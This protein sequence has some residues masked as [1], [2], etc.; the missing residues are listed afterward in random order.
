MKKTI[1]S[2]IYSIL[3]LT[4]FAGCKAPVFYEI[5]RDVAPE[6]ATVN[7][8]IRSITRYGDNLYTYSS[9][10]L[11]SKSKDASQHGE[12]KSVKFDELGKKEFILKTAANKDYLY[13]LTVSYTEE[14]VAGLNIP[15]NFKLW[16]YKDN[17]WTEVSGASEEMKYDTE[18]KQTNFNLFCTND[19]TVTNRHA[20]LRIDDDVKELSGTS[21]GS[22]A[23]TGKYN[24]AVWFGNIHFFESAASVATTNAVYW[25]KGSELWYATYTDLSDKKKALNAGTNI[26]CLAA[27]NDALLIGRADYSS[28]MYTKGGIAKTS[29]DSA[30]KPGDKLI[31]FTTNAPSQL[32]SSYQIY[33]LL[34]VD[35]TIPETQASIYASM[36]FK[37][38]GSSTSVSYDNIGLWSY[39]PTRGNWNRE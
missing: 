6:S 27:T 17:A 26:S 5:M 34:C 16:A 24:S 14:P 31:D 21:L 3:A 18:K 11:I 10:G 20:Y 2:F 8:V 39:Y 1:K 23:A 4:L 7:G 38:S 35:S 28:S 37:G 33:T 32:A 13:V 19:E 22:T 25:G 15:N 29:L 12:W 30:G 9:D 36:G